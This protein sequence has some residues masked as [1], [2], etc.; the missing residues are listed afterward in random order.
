MVSFILNDKL[1]S[2][3]SPQ[4]MTLLDFVRYEKNLVGT[5]I[6][7][8]EGDCGA[9]TVLI[10]EL[11]DGKMEY[12]SVTS[13]IT[14]LGNVSGKHVV[15]IEGLNMI[16]LTPV[17]QAMVDEAG[18]QCGFCTVGFVV[19]FSGLCLSNKVISYEDVI[20]GID[21][22]ICRCTGYKSIER[23]A[24][25]IYNNLKNKD[26]NNPVKWLVEQKFIP[27][28]FASIP[29]RIKNIESSNELM[30]SKIIV[31]GGTDLYVQKHDEM[32]DSEI[33]F[34]SNT[35]EFKGINIDGNVC[36]IG[37]ASTVSELMES[38]ELKALFP[39]L[40]KHL[41]LISSTQIRNIGTLAGNFIN[42]SPIGDLTVFFIALKSSIT[43]KNKANVERTI[44]LKDL[45]QGYKKLDKNEDEYISYLQFTIPDSS[46]HFNFEKVSKRTHLDIASVNTAVSIKIEANIICEI[47]LSA[48]G[49]G[50]IPLYLKNTCEFLK[51]KELVMKNITAAIEI[52]QKEIAPISDARGTE[53]YKRLLLRQLF[54]A[55]F[56]E[57]FPATF[58]QE[59]LA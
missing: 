29:E 18:T 52:M 39:N 58:N 44:L 15:S 25:R 9:C 53:E 2:T 47:N 33:N 20:S 6:G 41:K 24:E 51:R 10:G 49:V 46:T 55:H 5:K 23:A 4:G 7:C 50:P 8:R 19:S 31:G 43:F 37:S 11:N 3:D 34:I 21:G 38:I 42:A 26:L 22:N 17:Q 1:I 36:T 54:F 14:P 56:L 30:Q 45:Y 13:C 32:E 40:R 28:Y 57:L 12:K 59:I 16:E 27:E 35:K 48:G